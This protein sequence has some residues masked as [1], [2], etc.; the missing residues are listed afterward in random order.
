MEIN[1]NE[2]YLDTQLTNNS[3]HHCSNGPQGLEKTDLRVTFPD[4]HSQVCH[5]FLNQ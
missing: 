2:N 3:V 4:K 1:Y 5:L